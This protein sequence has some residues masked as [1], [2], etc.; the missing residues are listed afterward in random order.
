ML[1]NGLVPPSKK[2]IF[3]FP[4]RA[5][6]R[7][8]WIASLGRHE[9]P[10][11]NPDLS[12]VCE[13]HFHTQDFEVDPCP[14]TGNERQRKWLKSSAVP[15]VFTELDTVQLAP[16]RPTLL[17]AP[18]ARR[19]HEESLLDSSRKHVGNLGRQQF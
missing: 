15:S 16:P 9:S 1:A 13:L 8:L 14:R 3:S 11:L 7:S 10:V 5:D 18:S 17:A 4:K 19:A 2:H 12:G 6:V